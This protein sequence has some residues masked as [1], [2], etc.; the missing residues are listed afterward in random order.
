MRYFLI[1]LLILGMAF[2][3]TTLWGFNFLLLAVLIFSLA[4]EEK[5][6]LTL[7]FLS[8]LLLDLLSG[9][10]PAGGLG[11]SSLSF[12]LVSFLLIT[13]RRRFSFKNPFSCFV[14]ALVSY[15]LFSLVTRNSFNLW[16]GL[17]L[18]IF[19]VLF[20]L[21]L[22]VSPGDSQGGPFLFHKQNPDQL[23]I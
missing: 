2:F 9:G 3:Q 22:P 6:S 18:G 8:G 21:F 14:F 4:F 10:P 1:F 7:A 12:V 5:V 19:L 17:F 23:K 16:E 20:R 11:F 13:Y 15:F